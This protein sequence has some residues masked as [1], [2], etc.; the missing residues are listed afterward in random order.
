MVQADSDGL[1]LKLPKLRSLSPKVIPFLTD[2]RS[3]RILSKLS[4]NQIQTLEDIIS[5]MFVIFFPSISLSLGIQFVPFHTCSMVQIDLS[6][7]LRIQNGI[8]APNYT[9]LEFSIK[10]G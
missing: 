6:R 4:S 8:D 1:D 7:R 5:C 10:V 9:F 3:V 2:S